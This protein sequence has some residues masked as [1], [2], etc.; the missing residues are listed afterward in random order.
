MK[1]DISYPPARR[2]EQVDT[3]HG[4]EVPDPYRWLEEDGSDD[5]RAWVEA[6]NALT[7]RHLDG[8]RRDELVG[9]LRGLY[10]Y[11]RTLTFAGRGGRYFFTHNPGLLDQPIL[12]VQDGP[13]A[14]P[15]VLLDP[16]TL[17]TDGTTALT[18]YFPSPDGARVAYA[19]SVHGSDRQQ[20]GVLG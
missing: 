6:E 17:S 2:S 19:I 14:E 15:R 10:D 20:I 7:R 1:T 5:T 11:P 12:F 16:N 3:L 8:P 18:A 9:R 13:G 4:V